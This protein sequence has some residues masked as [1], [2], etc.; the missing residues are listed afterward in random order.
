MNEKS[1][2]HINKNLLE[3]QREYEHKIRFH[4]EE[5]NNLPQEST[6]KFDVTK[7]HSEAKETRQDTQIVSSYRNTDVNRNKHTDK[8]N[9]PFVSTEST[10]DK[11][12]YSSQTSN[13][14]SNISGYKRLNF[15]K[16]I[17]AEQNEYENKRRSKTEQQSY[18]TPL[19]N[20]KDE[21]ETSR[22][23]LENSDISDVRISSSGVDVK[24]EHTFSKK[25]NGYSVNSKEKNNIKLLFIQKQ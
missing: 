20:K 23:Q 11:S 1:D 9:L 3:E 25:D 18:R 21:K 6:T 2:I 4:T 13:E 19:N 24:T 7:P 15:N 14:N 5:K 8:H 22:E 10:H 12:L 17:Q 16:N